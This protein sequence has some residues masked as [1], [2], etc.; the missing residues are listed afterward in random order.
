MLRVKVRVGEERVIGYRVDGGSSRSI[1]G[2]GRF[3]FREL[4]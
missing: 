2:S 3:V 4:R 1:I